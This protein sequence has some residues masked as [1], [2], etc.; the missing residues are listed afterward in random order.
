[1]KFAASVLLAG[2]LASVDAAS[3]RKHNATATP[4]FEQYYS[5][6]EGRGMWKWNVALDAYQR[7]FG[8]FANKESKMLEIG[9]QSG[10]SIL[11]YKQVLPKT[12]YYGMDINKNCADFEDETTKIF[13]GDQA[14]V[15]SWQRFFESPQTAS[16]DMCI[17]DGGHQAFQ[18]LATLQ[19]VLPRMNKGGVFLTEDIH[20]QNEDYLTRFFYPAADFMSAQLSFNGAKMESVHLYPF[21]LA[22]Q[23]EGGPAP[24]PKPA[25]IAITVDSFP[26]LI[27]AIPKH[28]GKVVHIANKDWKS[29]FGPDALKNFFGTFYDMYGGQVRE[30]PA[31]CHN[32]M[33][34]ICTMI[35]TNTRY[36]SL[37][38]GVHIYAEEAFVEVHAAPP[39][40]DAVRRGSKWIPY[41]G[42]SL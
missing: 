9:V 33:A 10:G 4:T 14:D 15:P 29:L 19:Q 26:G 12:L 35:A 8:Q 40:I 37:I 38:K 3:L 25:E 1:M 22:V 30:E 31:H 17:D 28:L 23:M 42:P 5:G 2:L 34:N 7:H 24:W 18:M 41:N 11:M 13:L 39:V 20:G 36:Q 6:H 21:I 32:T 16:L 27:D